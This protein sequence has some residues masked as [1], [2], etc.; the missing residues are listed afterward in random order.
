M[1]SLTKRIH[2]ADLRTGEYEVVGISTLN[3][4]S[5][6]SRKDVI[7]SRGEFAG[8]FTEEDQLVLFRDRLGARN[9]Y[10]F[11][12]D[13]TA[14][15]SSDLGWIGQ[16]V[17]V[18]PNW[19]Y[20]LSDYLQF[21]IPFSEETFFKGVKKV[22]PGEFV[23]IDSSGN[24]AR[25]KYWDIDFGDKPFRA[26]ELSELIG[27]AVRFR[28]SQIE[29]SLYTAYLSGGIDS[30]TVALLAKPRECFSGFY[31]EEGYSE[32]DY[33]ETLIPPDDGR[34]ERY[35]PVQITQQAFRELLPCLPEIVPDP[36]AGLGVIP[37]VLVAQEAARQGYKYAFTGEGGDEIFLGYNWN[38]MVFSLAV[39]AKGLLRDR[40]MVHYEP[41]VEKVLRDGM[42]TLTGG[43]L[44]RG[45]DILYATKRILELWDREQPVENNILLINLKLGLPAI[46][47]LDEQVGR[48]ANVEPVSPLVDHHIVEYVCS[49]RP[50]DR[51]PIPKHM[52][53]EALKGILP[54]KIRMRYEK[55]GFPVPYSKWDW[56]MIE[57]MVISLTKRNVLPVD[58]EEHTTMDRKTW[59]LYS[60]EAW[61]QHFF[62]KLSD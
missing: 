20:I 32:M 6:L 10:Y 14:V 37:Q 35:I 60:I 52:V 5:N 39:A 19:D 23:T 50:D 44:A 56:P 58:V 45:D 27:D 54:E 8:F 61:C 24:L 25:E 7:A 46:L 51:A 16:Q 18:E 49:V 21:Q 41:M 36:C 2:L 22:M 31:E 38:T 48:Y 28:L 30:S 42:A 1:Q 15:V 3:S 11:V 47:T 43:L 53:R 34:P 33:I 59:A 17:K 62:G 13:G 29:G 4:I 55:M 40:Y 12:Q 57:P 9:I 26:E